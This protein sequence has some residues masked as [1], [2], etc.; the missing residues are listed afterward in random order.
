M[1]GMHVY[2]PVFPHLFFLELE[3]FRHSSKQRFH[4]LLPSE[5]DVYVIIYLP[6]TYV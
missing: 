4:F 1:A 3:H 5:V 2:I 6:V